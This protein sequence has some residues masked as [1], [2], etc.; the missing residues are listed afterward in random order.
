V[1]LHAVGTRCSA[2][3]HWAIWEP[4]SP[5][6]RAVEGRFEPRAAAPDPSAA[7]SP[8][9]AHRHVDATLIAESP[10]LA[11]HRERICAN[12][13]EALGM[14]PKRVSVKATTNE[15]LGAWAR[16]RACCVRGGDDRAAVVGAGE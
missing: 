6:G 9:R 11:P 1:L 7:R 13:A 16:R 2:P 8:G 5:G 4:I 14:E 10:K 15:R 3:L 12:V